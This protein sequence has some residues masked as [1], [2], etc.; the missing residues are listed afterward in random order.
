MIYY[1]GVGEVW[2]RSA[3]LCKGWSWRRNIRQDGVEEMTFEMFWKISGIFQTERG[4]KVS[5]SERHGTFRSDKN[6]LGSERGMDHGQ[7]SGLFSPRPSSRVSC[8]SG[9]LWTLYVLKNSRTTWNFWS[10]CLLSPAIIGIH[11]VLLSCWEWN[12]GHA[13]PVSTV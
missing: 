3:H 2:G 12:P 8:S 1:P 4:R 7:V 10:S 9:W 5:Q 11:H 6:L 13:R